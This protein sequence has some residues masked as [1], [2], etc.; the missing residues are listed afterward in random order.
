VQGLTVG[1]GNGADNQSTVFGNNCLIARTTAVATTAFGNGVLDAIT[2]GDS[3]TGF[4]NTAL[5]SC[6]IGTGNVAVGQAL[7]SLISGLTNTA[8]GSLALGAA[9]GN[10]NSALG[11]RSIL[12][13]VAGISNTAVGANAGDSQLSGNNNGFFGFGSYADSTSGDNQFNYGNGSVTSHKFRNGDVVLGAGNVVVASAKG[14]DFSATANSSGNLQTSELLADYEEGTW[15][16]TD[17]SGAGLAI[18]GTACKYTKIGRAVTIQGIIN[19]PATA[20]T[21]AGRFSGI[22]FAFTGIAPMNISY[23]G[24]GGSTVFYLIGG[25]A[26][27]LEFYGNAGNGITNATLSTLS[28]YFFGTYYI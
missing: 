28:I 21:A 8:V 18:T 24:A 19:Y 27:D 4:G 11:S 13:L 7:T 25:G 1:T 22:P 5:G 6:T 16:P 10:D 9:T 12:N 17:T 20:S 15:V 2:S 26:G 3:N 23:I 14:I